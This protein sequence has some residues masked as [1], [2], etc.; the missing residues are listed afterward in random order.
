M[1]QSKSSSNQKEL[2]RQGNP[3]AIAVLLNRAYE[4]YGISAQ[5][6]RRQ[7]CLQI[8]L[9]AEDIPDCELN[10]RRIVKG[11]RKFEIEGITTLEIYGSQRS[12]QIPAWSHTEKLIENI[13]EEVVTPP[14]IS[15]IPS[16]AQVRGISPSRKTVKPEATGKFSFKIS[17]YGWMADVLSTKLMNFVLKTFVWYVAFFLGS[18]RVQI[19]SFYK[20]AWILYLFVGLSG[21]VFGGYLSARLARSFPLRQAIATGFLSLIWGMFWMMGKPTAA[22]FSGYN[23]AALGLTV[24][25]AIL[26]YF[27]HLHGKNPFSILRSQLSQ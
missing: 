3:E 12:R 15:P 22:N 2:A 4:P 10:V 9:E 21:T 1:N 19:A 14:K 6:K 16:Q 17:I 25:A 7:D 20:N 11:L 23:L 8:V 24:P 26:G 27:L 18:D 13:T 5:V